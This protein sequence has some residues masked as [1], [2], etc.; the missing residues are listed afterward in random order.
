MSARRI[1]SHHPATCPLQYECGEYAD[2]LESTSKALR[3]LGPNIPDAQKALRNKILL[4]RAK[5]AL[6]SADFNTARS[7]LDNLLAADPNA[8]T[9]K[10]LRAAIDRVA[11][12]PR[13]NKQAAMERISTLPRYRTA[14]KHLLE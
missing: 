10:A 3:L 6:Q 13:G 11:E 4:R 7:A 1:S 9:A 14:P 2:A 12:I 8:Q 5:T